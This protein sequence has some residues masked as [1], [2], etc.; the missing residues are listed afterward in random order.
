MV[1]FAGEGSGVA[2]L[3]WG[4]YELWTAIVR[5]QNW[6][7]IGGTNPLP[8][9]TTVDDVAAELSYLVSRFQSIRTRLRFDGGALPQQVVAA[10]GEI[11]LEI[12]DAGTTDPAEVAATVCQR[13]QDTDFDFVNDWPLRMA[14]VCQDGVPKQQ[15]SIMCH[16][17]TDAFGAA[18]MLSQ[19]HA[20]DNTPI[21]GMQPLAQARWQGSP[22]GERQH[23]AA[24]RHWERTLRTMPLHRPAQPTQRCEP[25]HWQGEFTSTALHLAVRSIVERTGVDSGPVLLTLCAMSIAR[26]TG[27]NPVGIRTIVNNRFRPRLANVVGVIAQNALC[28]LDVADGPFEEVLTRARRTAMT[29]YK[30]AYFDAARIED[31]IDTVTAERGPILDA[32]CFFNDRRN[33]SRAVAAGPTPTCA[34]IRAAGP[35]TAVRWVRGQDEPFERLFIHINDVPDTISVQFFMDTQF[36]SQADVEACL[37]GMEEIAVE[38]ACA[39]APGRPR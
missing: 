12:V 31:L 6:L 37:R 3:S 19:V 10:S 24:M 30:H 34:Q 1:P 27:M 11:P 8:A 25:R 38:A 4:Q 29:A 20:R 35:A 15:V 13:Y 21:T 33:Q 32:A 18:V 17:V 14:V 39:T 28:V 5:Q 26:V 36:L 7:P 22:A 2:P 16:L 23:A 9:G